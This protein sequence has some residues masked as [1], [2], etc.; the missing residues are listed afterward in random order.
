MHRLKPSTSDCKS[1]LLAATEHAPIDARALG[2]LLAEADRAISDTL[3]RG[4][5]IESIFLLAVEGDRLGLFSRRVMRGKLPSLSKALRRP[6]R[7]LL[8]VPVRSGCVTLFAVAR[9]GKVAAG[10]LEVSSFGCLNAKGGAA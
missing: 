2:G 7:Q 10:H 5:S 8:R 3:A 1:L 6:I 4:L 9:D